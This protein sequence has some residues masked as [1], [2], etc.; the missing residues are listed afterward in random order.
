LPLLLF[1][2][3]A[4]FVGTEASGTR[5]FVGVIAISLLP[6]LV[7]G[8]LARARRPVLLRSDMVTRPIPS[9]ALAGRAS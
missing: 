6:E 7:S 4:L 1:I 3:L 8:A 9:F 2:P 5:A